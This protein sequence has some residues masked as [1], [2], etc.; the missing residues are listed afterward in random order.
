MQGAFNFF[1]KLGHLKPSEIHSK[2][3]LNLTSN[4]FSEGPVAHYC[5]EAKE[6]SEFVCQDIKISAK[7]M[8]D[9]VSQDV[10][11]LSPLPSNF[12]YTYALT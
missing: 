8:Y 5:H 1:L 6:F 12:D 9:E 2:T 10:M 11:D 4:S 7:E 3:L